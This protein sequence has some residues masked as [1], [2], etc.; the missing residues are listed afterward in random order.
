MVKKKLTHI[1]LDFETRSAIDLPVRGGDVYAK[2]PST[3]VLCMAWAVEDEAVTLWVTG[4]AAPFDLFLEIDDGAILICH[5]AAFEHAIW[6]HYCVPKLG[7]PPLPIER[8][9]CTMAMAYAMALPGSLDNASR[10]LG[11]TDGKDMLGNRVMKQLSQPRE[12]LPDGKVIWWEE[13]SAKDEVDRALIVEKFRVLH[14]YCVQDV[15]VERNVAK[16]LL[17][18]SDFEQQVWVLD[19]KINLRGVKIDMPM[20]K[21]A[22]AIVEFEQAGL[23]DK[24]VQATN[25]AVSSPQAVAQIKAFLEDHGVNVPSLAKQ[26]L[27]DLL[28]DEAANLP[29]NCVA[30]LEL[31]QMAAKSS[32]AKFQ[33]MLNRVSS[34]GRLRGMFQYHGAGTGRW[35]ARGVQLHN[36]PRPKISQDNIDSVFSLLGEME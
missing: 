29:K 36:L 33:T 34:D 24:M 19:Q 15:V 26:E 27:I 8:F 17:P 35:A 25:G 3:T 31:R 10:A 5:N 14:A 28:D 23:K 30:V 9:R 6:N 11:I 7:W 12:V 2:D 22:L 20:V 21:R 4:D 18:L 1:H 16:R 32:T 13:K